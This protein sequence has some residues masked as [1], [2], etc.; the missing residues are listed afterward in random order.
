MKPTALLAAM[1]ISP[2]VA[3]LR[4]L[5]SARCFTSKLPKPETEYF[6]ST[7]SAFW[8]V[9]KIASYTFATWALVRPSVFSATMSISSALVIGGIPSG[10]EFVGLGARGTVGVPRRA[11]AA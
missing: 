6:P 4:P 11:G 3:G 2:P 7:A 5:R 8:I 1:V 10:L 9:S